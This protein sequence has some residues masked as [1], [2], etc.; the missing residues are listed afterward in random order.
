MASDRRL[1]P[2]S[3]RLQLVG[4]GN[5]ARVRARGGKSTP[6]SRQNG[7]GGNRPLR[8]VNLPLGCGQIHGEGEGEEN[9][10][11]RRELLAVATA[12]YPRLPLLYSSFEFRPPLH[13][14]LPLAR[15]SV[16][17]SSS[18]RPSI[19]ACRSPAPLFELRVP[20]APPSPLA[21]RPLLC[22]SFEF[23][24]S[25]SPTRPHLLLP[26]RT[27]SSCTS[28][29]ARPSP[30]IGRT[31]SCR[32]PHL[33]FYLRRPSAWYVPCLLSVPRRSVMILS[34]VCSAHPFACVL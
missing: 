9:R 19:P 18:G 2:G 30:S 16:Q 14:R 28:G 32:C 4:V 8:A 31:C 21:A 3:G 22:S 29:L 26:V 25:A 20:A 6:H 11:R 17:A 7:I 10:R 13:P 23:R 15:S 5:R 1:Q 27:C 12:L 24:P 34:I 33:L